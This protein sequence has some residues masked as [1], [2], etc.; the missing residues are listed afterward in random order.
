MVELNN[1]SAAR[2]RINWS[3]NCNIAARVVWIDLQTDYY[4]EK[5]YIKRNIRFRYTTTVPS[6]LGSRTHAPN[7]YSNRVG[8]SAIHGLPNIKC[9]TQYTLSTNFCAEMYGT[10]TT[11]LLYDHDSRQVLGRFTVIGPFVAKQGIMSARHT[12]HAGQL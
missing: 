1:V 7:E 5:I 10:Y 4:K 8:I 6:S 2:A 9:E 11:Q 12:S 3:L